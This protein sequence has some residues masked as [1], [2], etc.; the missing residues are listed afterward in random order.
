[1]QSEEPDLPRSHLRRIIALSFRILSIFLGTFSLFAPYVILQLL[2]G[3]EARQS[4]VSQRIWMMLW[5]VVGQV[6]GCLLCPLALSADSSKKGRA[7]FNTIYGGA[8][9]RI[10]LLVIL[11]GSAAIG[12]YVVVAQTMLQDEVCVI[13]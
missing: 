8:G 2:T 13:V 10:L 3:F 1:M 12:G 4:S 11:P 6:Y 7:L 5:L 9:A